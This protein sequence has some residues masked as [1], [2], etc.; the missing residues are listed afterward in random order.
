MGPHDCPRLSVRTSKLVHTNIYLLHD[1]SC[2]QKPDITI[3]LL[4][5]EYASRYASRPGGYTRIH[6][7][8]NRLGDN[9]PHAVIELV[10]GPRD[11]R[12]EMTARAVGRETVEAAL[13]G[14]IG[15]FS[16]SEGTSGSSASGQEQGTSGAVLRDI[17]RKNLEKVLRYRSEG[18][19]QRFRQLAADW[20]VR[21]TTSVLIL[22]CPPTLRP[23]IAL[24]P[25]I[26]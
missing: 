3:P 11:L 14:R 21:R 17:T 26:I 12:F 13:S 18:D 25:L 23:N 9:A 22:D 8:G 2:A 6:L 7:Y 4:F 15:E 20:A 19:R 5:N 16:Y 24:E 1:S 10:D